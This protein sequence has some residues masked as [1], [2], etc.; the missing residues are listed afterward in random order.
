MTL[1]GRQGPPLATEGPKDPAIP[2]S[3]ACDSAAL[4]KIPAVLDPSWICPTSQVS[5]QNS[6]GFPQTFKGIIC[7][8]IPEFQS[9]ARQSRLCGSGW[10]HAY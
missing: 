10:F 4:L 6:P 8:D 5:G 7:G 2:G 3:M 9:S 1:L